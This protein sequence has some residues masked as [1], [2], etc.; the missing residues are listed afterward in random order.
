MRA[1]QTA[2]LAGRTAS[3]W[4]MSSR[5]PITAPTSTFARHISSTR[6]VLQEAEAVAP[7]QQSSSPT[8][9]SMTSYIQR[10]EQQQKQQAAAKTSESFSRNI[11]GTSSQQISAWARPGASISLTRG[12]RQT[13]SVVADLGWDQH[14]DVL[15]TKPT[16]Q[17]IQGH[18]RSRELYPYPEDIKLRLRPVLGR[19]VPLGT[20]YDFPQ[21]LRVLNQRCKSNLVATDFN[22]QRFYERP[23][24]KKK[25]L[26]MSRWRFRFKEGFRATCTRV[27]ELAKQGW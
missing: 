25:R 27:S 26:R 10:R 17:D 18:S 16:N 4:A 19:T 5:T 20:K 7:Q 24:M 8:S 1:V 12:E 9:D 21:A 3:R 15:A 6:K 22:R 2:L 14:L 23:G 11:F 13:S